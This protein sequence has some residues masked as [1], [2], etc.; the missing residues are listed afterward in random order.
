[1]G[2]T[3]GE[4]GYC[5]WSH[6]SDPLCPEWPQWFLCI[7]FGHEPRPGAGP[8]FIA[9]I[10]RVNDAL[11]KQ[12]D[13]PKTSGWLQLVNG[14]EGPTFVLLNTRKNWA[15]LAPLAK[16]TADVLNEAYG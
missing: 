8:D 9:A 12:A 16:T 6:K 2:G 5:R 4:G 13:W 11:G 7:S 1:M 14:G 3:H 10:K 15:D